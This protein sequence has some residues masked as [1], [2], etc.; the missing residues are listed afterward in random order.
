MASTALQM[1]YNVRT[2]RCSLRSMVRVPP[3]SSRPLKASRI[4]LRASQA[5]R[6]LLDRAAAALSTDRSSFLLSQGRLAAQQVLADREHFVLDAAAQQEWERINS[7]PAR[8]LP[9]LKRL[10]ERP[11]PFVP[12][13]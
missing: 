12:Q 5:D 7:C 6:D 1:P 9:G 11:S 8:V 2:F 3:P 10:L 4:E 13:A